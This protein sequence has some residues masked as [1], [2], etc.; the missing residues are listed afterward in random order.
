MGIIKWGAILVY[1][2]WLDYRNIKA[3]EGHD[4]R[5]WVQI[6]INTVVILLL[7]LEQVK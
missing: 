7:A 5:L 2:L 4:W 1:W 3:Q 6:A